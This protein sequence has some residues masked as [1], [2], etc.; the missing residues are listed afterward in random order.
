[1]WCVLCRI[2]GG[3]DKQGFPMM[4]G[5]LVNGRVRL[6]MGL[7]ST[8]YRPRRDGE[9]R[10]KS[11]RGCIVGPDIAILNLVVVKQGEAELPGLT[12][13]ESVRPRRLGP[14]RANKIRKL[15]NL[16]K[17]QDVR[18]FVIARTF[19]NKKGKTI[20]KRPKIQRLVTPRVLQRKA[21]L[22]AEKR[23]AR[24][25]ATEEKAEYER[26]KQQ[27]HK[28]ATEKKLAE[29]LRRSSRRKSSKKAAVAAASG[30]PAPKPE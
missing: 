10:R 26:L 15:F 5:V 24:T 25:K 13:K 6:L 11:V 28:E 23:A 22:L 3:N 1:M 2:S 16:T 9:R 7:G 8:Y 29:K 19:T 18:K 17:E 30:A 4:Q 21:A 12:D 20:T 14:K 27:R